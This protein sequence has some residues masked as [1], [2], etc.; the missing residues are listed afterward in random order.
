M[1][2]P[3]GVLFD[4]G[5]TVIHVESYDTAA[6]R[7][8][9]LE[10]ANNA[11]S[12]SIEDVM[13]SDDEIYGEVKRIKE[14][15]MLEVAWQNLDRLLFETLGISFTI[16]Y[17]EL[18]KEFWQ[19][20]VKM[21]PADGIFDV[22]DILDKNGIKTGIISNTIF[23]GAVLEEE[24]SRH[25]LAHRFSFVITSAD[26]GFRK[27]HHRIFQI[28][29]KKM[30]LEAQDIWFVGDK[31]EYDVKGAFH[32]GLFPIWY[33]P[34]NEPGKPDYEYLEV[35]DWHEFRDRIEWLC[36]S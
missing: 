18:E 10:F 20:A 26:Y 27:P 24:L 14:E 12:I 8:R 36:T 34:R 32:S 17:A 28:A 19:A 30:E 11:S 1:Q 13:R 29:V 5:D 25:N 33:N 15:S 7:K 23:S 35:K 22:L 31:L 16:S 3:S 6:G 4:F 2:R 21:A 9:L